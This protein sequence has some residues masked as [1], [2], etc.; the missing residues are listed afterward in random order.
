[1]SE[2]LEQAIENAKALL[3]EHCNGFAIITL[4]YEDQVY[5]DYSS[6]VV[7]RQLLKEGSALLGESNFDEVTNIEEWG[8]EPD[9]DGGEDWKE[10]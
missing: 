9:E 8:E 10:T 7:A 6:R 2:P 1:M 4:D 5:T 3:F